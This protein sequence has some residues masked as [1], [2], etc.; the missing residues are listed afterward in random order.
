LPVFDFD[1]LDEFVDEF[2]DMVHAFKESAGNVTRHLFLD[3][4]MAAQGPP[5]ISNDPIDS[6]LNPAWPP[7]SDITVRLKGST[8]MLVDTGDMRSF[9]EWRIEDSDV[10][11]APNS[12]KFGWFE[13]AGD[14][15]WIAAIHEFGLT[16]Q[17][18]PTESGEQMGGDPVGRTVTARA[19]VRAWLLANA[20]VSTSGRVTIPRRSM[21][22]KTTDLLEEVLED[23]MDTAILA[24]LEQ[25]Q[26]LE[27]EL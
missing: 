14:R 10:G 1:I 9:A 5:T 25:I 27:I 20:G 7:L 21:L 4:V 17:V 15:A 19:R 23:L 2:E 16:G 3:R 13:N 18:F 26:S 22:G 11:G 6:G 24:Q 8:G 12:L